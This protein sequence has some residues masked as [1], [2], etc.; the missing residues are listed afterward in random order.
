MATSPNR[1]FR[2]LIVIALL[3]YVVLWLAPFAAHRW[4]EVFNV[5]LLDFDG[6]GALIAYSPVLYWC[7]FASWLL[8]LTGLF[9][10]VPTARPG[11]V[12]LTVISVGLGFVWGVRVLTPYEAALGSLLAIIDGA[13]I[14]MAYWSP[15]QA[16]FE[17]PR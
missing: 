17:R 16:K 6:Y 10:H 5:W 11:F 15:V 8:I 3:L 13:L 2:V 9:F 1:L 7:L 4:L 12:I 14:A